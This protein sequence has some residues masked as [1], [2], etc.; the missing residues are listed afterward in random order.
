IFEHFGGD[1]PFRRRDLREGAGEPHVGHTR[2][3]PDVPVTSADPQ[4]DLAE[5]H[6][7]AARAE[8]PLLDEPGLRERLEYELARRGELAHDLDLELARLVDLQRLSLGHP[9]SSPKPRPRRLPVRRRRSSA[10][11]AW[12]AWPCRRAPCRDRRA[13][14]AARAE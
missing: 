2:L 8:H 7:P 12:P 13:G 4:V 5:W 10:S 9:R 3:A 1:Q 6:R 11:S 14:E